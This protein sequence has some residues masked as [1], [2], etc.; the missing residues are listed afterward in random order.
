M[1]QNV[2][3]SASYSQTAQD[4]SVANIQTLFKALSTRGGH[5]GVSELAA[6]ATTSDTAETRLQPD[7]SAPCEETQ[8]AEVKRV[9]VFDQKEAN[10]PD[11]E[12]RAEETQNH[13]SHHL[14]NSTSK[15]TNTGRQTNTLFGVPAHACV[16]LMSL[17]GVRVSFLSLD[18]LPKLST[19]S[20]YCCL[21]NAIYCS[22]R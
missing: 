4:I 16:E 21:F 5:A 19:K 15:I 6:A 17:N 9:S 8:K 2:F 22:A 11:N 1:V 7:P 13:M 12:A 14:G 10:G 18:S 3:T 20:R